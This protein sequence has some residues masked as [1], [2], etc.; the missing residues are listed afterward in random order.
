[1]SVENKKQPNLRSQS[2]D[3]LRFPLAIAVLAVHVISPQTFYVKGEL[4]NIA[5][6]PAVELLVN[7]VSAFIR[8]QSV[9]I[10]YFISGY[11][12]FRGADFSFDVYNKKLKNRF[13]SL[14]VPYIVWNVLALLWILFKSM[15]CF[16]S[17]TSGLNSIE[18]NLSIKALLFSFWDNSLG[19]FPISAPDTCQIYPINSPLWFIRDLMIVVLTS[20]LV[21]WVVKKLHA[22][23]VCAMLILWFVANLYNWEYVSQIITAYAFFMWGAY[24]SVNKKDMMKEFGRFSKISYVGYFGLAIAY[25]VCAYVRPDFCAVLKLMNIFVGLLFAYNIAA[26]LIKNSICKPNKFLSSSS[27]FIYISHFLIYNEVLKIL[28]MILHPASQLAFVFLYLLAVL[29]CVL[30]LLLIFY[31]MNRYAPSI[32][33]VIAGRK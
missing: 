8:Q 24:M 20:P 1:M 13:R 18:P 2:L 10:Y 15:P 11:V 26:Y 7:I 23:S 33:K 19:V 27:F 12:F 21:Y 30:L 9:P 22:Y 25:L 28:F 6:M 16:A 14:F 31:L 29:V 4:I 32:L 5:S 17:L 3:L